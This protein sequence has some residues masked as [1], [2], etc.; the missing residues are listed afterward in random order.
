MIDTTNVGTTNTANVEIRKIANN[1]CIFFTF[2][3]ILTDVVADEI[4]L[5][6]KNILPERGPENDLCIICDCVHMRNYEAVARIKFQ[7]FILTHKNQIKVLWII[8]QNKV[9][10]IGAQIMAAF[11]PVPIKVVGSIQEI[12]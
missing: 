4:L 5:K 9:I 2:K 7:N 3:G 12:K 8:T 11:L 10:Q 6:S 1:T